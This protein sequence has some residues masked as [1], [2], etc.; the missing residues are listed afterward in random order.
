MA[1]PILAIIAVG[2][3][4]GATQYRTP[5]ICITD[6]ELQLLQAGCSVS[7][8]LWVSYEAVQ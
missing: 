6:I 3:S 7:A 8:E 4:G 1:I 5:L 2:F